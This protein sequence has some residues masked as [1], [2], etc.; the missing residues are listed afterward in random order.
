M[1]QIKAVAEKYAHHVWDKQDLKIIDELVHPDVV[2]HSLLGDYRGRRL[3]KEVVQKWLSAL[4]DLKVV[5]SAII[6]EN[7]LVTIQWQAKG[8]HQGEFKGIPATGKIVTYAGVSIYRISEG[9]ITEYWAYLDM[10]HLLNQM[11]D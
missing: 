3:M 10:Q 11:K 7:D 8:S 6:C 5:N 4:P 1:N 2:I 9:V